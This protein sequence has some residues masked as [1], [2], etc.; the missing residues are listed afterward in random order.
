MLSPQQLLR[1]A[2]WP[3]FGGTPQRNMINTVEKNLP[4]TWCVEK[5]KTRNIKWLA[6]LGTRAYGS[7]VIAG[8]K[9]FLGTNNYR[10]RNPKIKGD[11]GIMMCFRESDGKFLWQAVHDKLESGHVNDWPGEGIPS[12]PAVEGNRLYYV[13]NR[14]ELVCAHTEG[15]LDGKNDGIQDEQYRDKTDADIIWRLDMMKELKV[16][17]HN[18]AICSPLIAGDLVFV[19]TGNGVDENHV[20]V[21]FPE[22]PSF[23][24]VRKKTGKVVWKDNSPGKNIMHG[25]WSNPTYAVV[26]DRPQVIF[27]GGDG[28]LRAFE[29]ET[30][31]LIWKFDAN[32]K[33]SKY[34]LGGRGGR[35]DFIATAVVYDNKLYIGVGQDP[36]HNTGVGHLWCID[37]E[38]AVRL[39]RRNK[40]H[41]VS[42]ISDTFDPK[43]PENKNSALAWHYGGPID[44]VTAKKNDQNYL[45]QELAQACGFFAFPSACPLQALP[46]RFLSPELPPEY[47]FGRTLS[48]C[49]IHDDLVYLG[50][51]AGYL[52]CLDAKTGRKYWEH[53]VKS[54]LWGSAYWADGKVYIGN[55]DGDIFVFAHGKEK[56]LL[57]TI[58][59]EHPIKGTPVAANGVLYVATEGNLYAIA[60]K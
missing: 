9:I 16:F 60:S 3:M 48:T 36:E 29:P 11:K 33:A 47:V 20:N 10:P 46:A 32:P 27:P 44:P 56:K 15:F 30:G 39:G 58:E 8:G 51:I 37:L 50:E 38:R 13:S 42:P 17:P 31:K 21:P 28:W 34:E 4:A 57:G 12:M 14:C 19:V 35:N 22:A 52:H 26:A 24:A 18:L 1:A 6:R 5:G 45:R 40:D 7:P 41:D 55:E 53:D 25:Q 59:M 43:A 54:A 23:L 2:D 49:A